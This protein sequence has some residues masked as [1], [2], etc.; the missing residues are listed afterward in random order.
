MSNIVVKEV[1][2]KSELR[3]FVDYPN[4]LY[5]DVPQ[6]IPAFYGDDMADWDKS[7]N[8]AFDY[9]EAKAF[10]AYKEGE[11]V[12]RIG[13]ILSHKA[14]KTW[15]TKRMRFSQVDFIDDK[16]VSKAL[17]KTV[18]DWAREK[19][20]NEVH[21]PL[22]FCDLDREGMLVE[23][24]DRKGMFITYYNHPYYIEHLT[25]LGYIKDVDWIENLISVDE[26]VAGEYS[27][28]IERLSELA[29]K[30]SKLHIVKVKSRRDYKPYIKKVFE[31]INDAYAPLYG[32]VELTQKQIDKYATKFIPLINPDL[33]CFV[34]N[35]NNELVAFGVSAPSVANAMKKCRGRL[36]PIGWA[37]VLRALAKNDTIDL[38]LM[39]VKPDLQRGSGINT[40]VLNHIL[41]GCKKNNIHW[42]E[43]GPQLELNTKMHG[44]WKMLNPELHKRRRCFIKSL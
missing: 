3:K 11:I 28:R 40:I 16:E 2:T 4:K 15:G 44:Q 37:Y 30:K 31:L 36:F 13:A 8:P 32:V 35:E 9:C 14:N 43:T 24:F 21:G 1:L 6:F 42:A 22:G 20:C 7:K 17:F 10:L 19:D 27:T 33:A 12:G 23:G 25:E 5:K 39:A 26:I 29:L 38:F 41:Q 18:E 34:E